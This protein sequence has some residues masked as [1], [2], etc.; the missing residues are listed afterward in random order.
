MPCSPIGLR[1][2]LP[3]DETLDFG[4]GAA[5]DI[6][7]TEHS[8]DNNYIATLTGRIGEPGSGNDFYNSSLLIL[9]TVNGSRLICGLVS[10]IVA[11]VESATITLSGRSYVHYTECVEHCLHVAQADQIPPQT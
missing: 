11:V 4:T 8:S 9:E 5:S 1:W 7:A 6:G 3:N 10:L 2:I